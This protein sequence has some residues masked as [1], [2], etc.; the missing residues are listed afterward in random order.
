MK[1]VPPKVDLGEAP[2][3]SEVFYRLWAELMDV[4]FRMA[5]PESP[6]DPERYWPAVELV[7]R[8]LAIENAERDKALLRML[9]RRA[10]PEG[11]E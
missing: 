7:G 1:G 5:L 8:G 11:E 10:L 4:S 2:A 9:S 3:N 6:D